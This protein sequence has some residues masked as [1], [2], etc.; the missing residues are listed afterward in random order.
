MN[1]K[2]QVSNNLNL[3]G[4]FIAVVVFFILLSLFF[5]LFFLVRESHFDG[6][7]KYNLEIIDQKQTQI[8]SFSPKENSISVLKLDQRVVGDLSKNLEI[9]IDGIINFNKFSF[10]DSKLTS[11]ILHGLLYAS[12]RYKITSLDILRLAF[13]SRKVNS[14]SIYI[15]QFQNNYTAT[16]KY[17]VLYLTF[18]DP[19]IFTQNQT[20]E[21]INATD[22]FGLG[23][24]L[25]T[26]ISVIGGNVIFV[27]SDLT[28][29]DSKI[30][31]NGNETYTEKR[32]RDA[33]GFPLIKTTEKGVAD[34]IIIIGTD[35]LKNLSF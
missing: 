29:K 12:S 19:V 16:Q 31:Y 1:G 17:N 4:I 7:N 32:I 20:I 30:L 27:K 21:I 2:K 25:A 6:S 18:K 22:V 8:I 35:S 3:A 10:D 33:T 24:R 11:G 9:P 26:L 5:K 14:G 34:V 23:N 28:S 13:F 15:R